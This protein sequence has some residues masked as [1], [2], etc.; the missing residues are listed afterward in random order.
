MH[1][2]LSS[3]RS[4]FPVKWIYLSANKV[5]GKSWHSPED[6]NSG[7]QAGRPVTMANAPLGSLGWGH[8]G[9]NF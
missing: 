4:N 6:V 7:K 8:L 2:N 3:K 1:H 9:H 5:L